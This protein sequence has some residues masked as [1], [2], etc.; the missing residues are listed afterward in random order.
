M[1]T[2]TP[3]L[4]ETLA[5]RLVDGAL[6]EDE[7]RRAEAHAAACPACAAEVEGWRMLSAALD[8]LA[9]PEPPADFTAA[10]LERIDARER[11]L[12][13]E[14]RH[15]LVIVAAAVAATAVAFA[16]A[17]ARAWA[18]VVSQATDAFAAAVRVVHV[19]SA[20]LPDVVAALRFQIIL[21]AAALALPLL[22]GLVRLMPAPHREIA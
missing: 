14:R 6:P 3:H 2:S 9:A 11:A 18:P 16:A 8:D 21:A 1:T 12:A 10:V 7:R 22:L 13:R 19:G 20:F 4:D 5:Q 17:G 15:A